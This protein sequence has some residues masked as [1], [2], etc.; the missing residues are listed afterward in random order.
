MSD[1]DNSNYLISELDAANNAI[2]HTKMI[3]LSSADITE[4]ITSVEKVNGSLEKAV[5]A[6]RN[7]LEKLRPNVTIPKPGAPVLPYINISGTVRVIEYNWLHI[8]LNTLL[9]HC[10][11]QTPQYLSDTII[12]LLDAYKVNNG[13]LPYYEN[14]MLI[15]DEHCDI[16]SRTVYDQDNKGYK[17]ISNA[18]KGRLFSDDDQF[19][20]G[21]A[22]I[23]TYDEKPSCNIFIIEASDAG[24]FFNMY[25]GRSLY[26]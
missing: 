12:R 22:L 7:T 6:T 4:I 1:S 15:I 16:K 26:W 10:R 5:I 3:C 19:S 23:S 2:N 14:A 8:K 9:P 25:Y 24:N 18:L 17:S 11:F 13:T 20:L 21:I